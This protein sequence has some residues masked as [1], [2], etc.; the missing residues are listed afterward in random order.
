M[1]VVGCLYIQQALSGKNVCMCYE[2]HAQSGSACAEG[3][4]LQSS[5]YM[6]LHFRCAMN[7]TPKK[8]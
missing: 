8:I 3:V 6:I 1:L 2:F 4:L 7:S 5:S